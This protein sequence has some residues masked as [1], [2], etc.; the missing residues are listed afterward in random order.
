M[1]RAHRSYG[2]R[3]A[4]RS[5]AADRVRDRRVE[6]EELV[7]RHKV[8]T[9]VLSLV[10]LS[11]VSGALSGGGDDEPT[12]DSPAAAAESDTEAESQ[13]EVEEVADPED[14]SSGADPST[15]T[16]DGANDDAVVGPRTRRSRQRTTSTPM[17]M[18]TRTTGTTSEERQLQHRLR[19][20]HRPRR[21]RCL[22]K[23]AEYSEDADGDRVADAV[24]AFP[25][26]PS[27]LRSR[28]RWRTRWRPLGSTW[29]TRRSA[30]SASSTS[31]IGVRRRVRSRRRHIGGRP[32]PVDWNEQAVKSERQCLDF[33]SFSR[34][35]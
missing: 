32:T 30:G 7:M 3:R 14:E 24:D 10:V 15:P 4:R 25:S 18:V 27:G 11:G 19:Q 16:G 35:D 12:T 26:S 8:V 34:R 2:T 6:E 1:D 21:P 5:P 23:D 20:G 29:T 17:A 33:S 31:C 9:V 22:P 13:P 28:W